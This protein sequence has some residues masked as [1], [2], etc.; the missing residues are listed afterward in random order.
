VGAPILVEVVD[1]DVIPH[2][3]SCR[4]NEAEPRPEDESGGVAL[5]PGSLRGPGF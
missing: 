5:I 2:I 3:D 1:V 4:M